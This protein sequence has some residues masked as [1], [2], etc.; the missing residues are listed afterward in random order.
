M[1]VK[2][3]ECVVEPNIYKDTTCGGAFHSIP[4]EWG[5]VICAD[6]V[7]SVPGTQIKPEEQSVCNQP[8]VA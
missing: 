7:S 4:C 1:V 3:T 6:A 8:D 2:K 5:M